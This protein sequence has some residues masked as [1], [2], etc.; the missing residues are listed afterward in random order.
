MSNE[1]FFVS[2]GS[3]LQSVLSLA[4]VARGKSAAD[5]AVRATSAPHVY[6]FGELLQQPN[7]AQM[8]DVEELRPYYNL[9]NLFAY[10]TYDQYKAG[11]FDVPPLSTEQEVKLRH[12]T[13]AT[14][15]AGKQE[16]SYDDLSRVLYIDNMR[17][18]EDLLIACISEG[19]IKGKFNQK[20]KVF[21]VDAV[22]GRDLSLP[23]DLD[24]LL[25]GL[26]EWSSRIESTLQEIQNSASSTQQNVEKNE[27]RRV[28][29]EM[30]VAEN[31]STAQQA[32]AKGDTQTRSDYQHQVNTYS[33]REYQDRL[34]GK[35]RPFKPRESLDSENKRR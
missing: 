34:R 17:D 18:L 13:V 30:K 1:C 33:S 2:R 29:I 32:L 15:C 12:L 6:V 27:G 22:M 23:N 19:I 26:L 8:A 4:S 10:G 25:G 28:A 11:S 3:S 21:C 14:T 5:L 7:I 16:V 24:K 31:Q 9:L 35:S 20:A